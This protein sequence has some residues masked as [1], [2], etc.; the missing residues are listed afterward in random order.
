MA[1]IAVAGVDP[2]PII[3]CH[4]VSRAVDPAAVDAFVCALAGYWAAACR[5]PGPP[6]SPGCVSIS[7][8]LPASS[9]RDWRVVLVGNNPRTDGSIVE[10]R[11]VTG[12]LPMLWGLARDR[13]NRSMGVSRAR[14]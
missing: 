4:P 9:E 12:C 5:K 1:S 10:K 13:I 14:K 11:K 6:R 2:D 3:A 8:C 7:W